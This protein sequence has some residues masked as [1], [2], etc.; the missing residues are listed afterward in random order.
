MPLRED[1][2]EPIAG[3]NPSGANLYY[4]KL[5][6]QIKEA[7]TEEAE[8][9][10][11]G[12]WERAPK[13]ADHILVIKLTG[14][15]LAKRSKDLRLAGWL[16]ESQIKREGI[17][18][19]AP[20]L[21]LLYKLQE[22]FWNTLYPEIDEDGDLGLRVTAIEGTI[23]RLATLLRNAPINKAGHGLAQYSES[24]RMGYEKAADTKEKKAARQDCIDQGQTSPEDFDASFAATP[25]TFYVATEES[26]TVAQT[27][28]DELDRFDEDKYGDDYP[29]LNKL[30]TAINEVKQVVSSLLNEKRKTEP[31]VVE[32]PP[33]PEPEPEPVVI[34]PP[35]QTVP[36]PVATEP[37][38]VVIATPA[39]VAAV[40]LPPAPSEVRSSS[41]PESVEQA[42]AA[43][44]AGAL[45]LL[46]EDA[47]SPVAYLV[48]AGVRLGETR[49]K[50]AS[51]GADFAIAPTTEIRQTLRK[52]ATEA[53]W[54]ELTKQC[55]KTLTQPSGR[56]WLDLHRYIW[57]AARETNAPAVG[58]AVVSTLR[59]LLQ[60][61]PEV[62]GWML[63]DDTP[64]ANA[65]TI[66]WIDTEV[67]PPPPPVIE[68]E[69]V[70][71]EEPI[72]VLPV[73]SSSNGH[74]SEAPVVP[75]LYDTAVEMLKRGKA[76]EAITLL[77]R[78]AEL[79]PS[80]RSRFN[81]RVQVAQLC[82]VADQDPVAYPVLMELSQEIERRNL[83][84][85]E[86]G[87]MLAHPLSLLLTCLERRKGSAEHKE[88]VFE[89]LCRLDPQAAM[90]VRR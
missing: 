48:C 58:T 59:G 23:T 90:A 53:N 64:V 31:D 28:L 11:A 57:K 8:S 25:K 14:D 19:L 18:V 5:F 77:V 84:T 60:D 82:L 1:L 42:C 49:R 74:G 47:Q 6:D 73:P 32:E 30:A 17:T 54:A 71:V 26:L 65:E 36:T 45:Y 89:R 86:S 39:P 56:A 80:G 83:E 35:V 40:S 81:R 63:D 10:S 43:V 78:D 85:W 3:E 33:E 70:P 38:P 52:L 24:Q 75:E 66:A 67:F 79:Q 16:L 4:D 72:N 69:T 44:L 13:K 76:R 37:P 46:Q 88:A 50:G 15:A 12:A 61:V 20:G 22:K 21:D 27:T 68:A 2:L 7:R 55:L 51:P 87:E 62:R 29:G 9:G 41:E 34:A